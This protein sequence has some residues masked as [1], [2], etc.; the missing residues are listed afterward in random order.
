MRSLSCVLVREGPSD[1]WFLPVVLQRALQDM[2]RE[3]FPSCGEVQEIRSLPEAGDQHPDSV[4]RA[5]E[6]ELGTFDVALYHHDGA[7][8]GKSDVVIKRMRGAWQEAGFQ[9]PLVPVVPVRETEAWLLADPEAIRSALRV[10]KL[11]EPGF[12]PER[13]HSVPRPKEEFEAI[14]RQVAGRKATGEHGVRDYVIRVGATV[15]IDVLRRV[16]AFR[17]WWDE[18]IEALERLGYQH[19]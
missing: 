4:V 19:G 14:V 18:M 13:V 17:Q 2:C 3:R 16:P 6:A 8:T 1:D 7:P 5:I 12:A 11:P 15:E 10:R 9:E